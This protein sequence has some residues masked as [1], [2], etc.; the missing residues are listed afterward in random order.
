MSQRIEKEKMLTKQTD[1]L[2]REGEEAE[3]AR[4]ELRM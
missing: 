3:A 1:P 4:C 2:E